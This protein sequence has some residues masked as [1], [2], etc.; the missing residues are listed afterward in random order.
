M[1]MTD[2]ARQHAQVP[3]GSLWQREDHIG[4]RAAGTECGDAA[5][6]GVEEFARVAQRMPERLVRFADVSQV[7][8]QALDELERGEFPLDRQHGASAWFS[9]PLGVKYSHGR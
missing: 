9:N 6:S 5:V 2:V 8:G 3:V 7:R 1:R 4:V